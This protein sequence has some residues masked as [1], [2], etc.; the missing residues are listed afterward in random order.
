MN[1]HEL[2]APYLGLQDGEKSDVDS[3][4]NTVNGVTTFRLQ[5][6][7]RTSEYSVSL[8]KEQG[9][10]ALTSHETASV[11]AFYNAKY[12]YEIIKYERLP[13]AVGKFEK[14]LK[15]EDQDS[16]Y[17]LFITTRSLGRPSSKTLT[18]EQLYAVAEQL[19]VLH[20]FYLTNL[21][22]ETKQII[23]GNFQKVQQCRLQRF[24]TDYQ[25]F[26]DSLDTKFSHYFKDVSAIKSK[27]ETLYKDD[28]DITYVSSL[29]SL[30]QQPT[31][32]CHGE[33]AS[34]KIVFN[35]NDVVEIRDWDNLSF[36]VV[37]EDLSYLIITSAST[38][39]RRNH[40]MSIFRRYYY[41]LVDQ[42]VSK[43]RL[44][45]LKEQF[46]RMHKYVVLTNISN[47][48]SNL[49]S[50]N[51]EENSEFVLRWETA[52]D[53]AVAIETGDYLSDNEDAFFA[54]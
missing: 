1:L 18:I 3:I 9:K 33:L 38:D 48:M 12:F 2:I 45:D 23:D 28:S 39:V 21:E 52:L 36:G 6:P 44:F 20:A 17:T 42:A 7:S 24:K 47:L 26:V 54:N 32:L 35:N 22:P 25:N 30:M 51:G 11:A 5:I 15:I 19:S 13:F 49:K 31:V 37:G 34:D 8:V 29:P 10:E 46:K 14:A 41:K 4:E 27:L 50:S 43:F 16:V 40:Y 53:D